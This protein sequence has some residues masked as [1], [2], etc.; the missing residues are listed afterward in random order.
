MRLYSGFCGETQSEHCYMVKC[1]W[2]VARGSWHFTN[3][4]SSLYRLKCMYIETICNLF[5]GGHLWSVIYCGCPC[6]CACVRACMLRCVIAT[7]QQQ[8]P[9][10]LWLTRHWNQLFLGTEGCWSV[11]IPIFSKQSHTLTLCISLTQ[12]NT[13][14]C[15]HSYSPELA[16]PFGFSA[17][18][19]NIYTLQ[20]RTYKKKMLSHRRQQ[21]MYVSPFCP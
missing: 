20:Q 12:L 6:V 11:R 4:H 16:F 7:F 14:C 13:H 5:C 1:R 19:V 8:K 15:L 9:E 3:L 21:H 2:A 18:K 17:V 10:K